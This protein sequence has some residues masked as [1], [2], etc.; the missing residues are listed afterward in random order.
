MGYI[1]YRHTNSINGKVYIGQTKGT[2]ESRAKRDGRGYKTG[3][4]KNA[5]NKYGWD[6]FIHEI[7]KEN[8]TKQKANEL[9][10]QLILEYK[11]KGIS[12]NITDGGEG[13]VGF[14]H[15]E[16]AKLKMSRDRKGRPFPEHL[17]QE[18]SKRFKNKKFTESHKQRIS[19]SLKGR[20]RTEEE[21]IAMRNAKRRCKVAPVLMFSRDSQFLREFPSIAEAANELGIKATHISRAARGVRPSAGG[22][23]WKYK[24]NTNRYDVI[25]KNGGL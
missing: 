24:S 5:I 11:Q 22:Y 18:V 3:I 6:A 20:C 12:Y 9:E 2:I 1:V 14:K 13:S 4:F 25:I 17:K 8:L 23:I 7:I 10:T 15:S 19:E 21:K 16:E